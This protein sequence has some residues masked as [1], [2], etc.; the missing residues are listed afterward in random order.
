MNK[1]FFIGRMTADAELRYTN[2]QLAIASFSLAV[3]DG[4]GDKKVTSFFR[5][6]AFGKRAESLQ[7]YAS[8][9]TKIAVECRA[10][11]DNW[12]DKEGNKRTAIG[13]IV[14]NWE[15]A[16]S[17]HESE[18]ATPKPETDPDGFMNIPDGLD[19]ELPFN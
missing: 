7:K 19:E 8:K 3:D 6:T 10:R 1:C 14:D 11:Q 5:M 18:N 9:G 12:T 17:S 13:F 2:E 15:F 4:Y 16:Q